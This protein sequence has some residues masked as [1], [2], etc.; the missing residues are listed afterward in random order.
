MGHPGV[1]LERFDQMITLI[2]ECR[3][4]ALVTAFTGNLSSVG[5]LP[6]SFRPWVNLTGWLSLL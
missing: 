5:F 3:L 4:D 1:D 2:G 6:F